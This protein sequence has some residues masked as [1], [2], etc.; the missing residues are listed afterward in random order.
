MKHRNIK[1]DPQ[2]GPC[3]VFAKFN[4]FKLVV[5]K[6]HNF[7]LRSFCSHPNRIPAKP[8]FPGF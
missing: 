5:K 3:P 8:E 2:C 1:H 6:H 7:G 4:D